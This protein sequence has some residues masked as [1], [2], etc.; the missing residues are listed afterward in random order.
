M[1]ERQFLIRFADTAAGI[2]VRST[3][4]LFSRSFG[5][6]LDFLLGS[7]LET[8][9]HSRTI[10]P[11]KPCQDPSSIP[12]LSERGCFP[13]SHNTLPQTWSLQ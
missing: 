10:M 11:E 4:Q 13:E 3:V 2:L 6:Q 1:I 7:G 9:Y 8:G 5:F 12:L